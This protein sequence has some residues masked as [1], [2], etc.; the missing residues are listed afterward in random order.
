[1]TKLIRTAF[2][3]YKYTEGH[4]SARAPLPGAGASLILIETVSYT[5]SRCVATPH[6]FRAA[7]LTAAPARA[8]V[9]V[10]I[11]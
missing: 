3:K 2:H 8:V 9:M 1:M 7:R 10:H 11:Y 4:P 5:W 6:S